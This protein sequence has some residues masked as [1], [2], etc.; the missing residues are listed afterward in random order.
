MR[1]APGTL[2]EALARLE[3]QGL[4]EALEA[5]GAAAALPA[6]RGGRRGA[7][8]APG[9]AA[10]GDRYRP[11][12]SRGQLGDRV[13]G[14]RPRGSGPPGCCAG[15][16][17]PGGSGTARS[18][19]NCSIAEMEER[20]RSAGRTLD[21]ARAGL[22]P[23][24]RPR[25]SPVPRCLARPSPTRCG[26]VSAR[27]RRRSRV[28]LALGAAMW[29]QLAI[30]WRWPLAPLTP[31]RIVQPAHDLRVRGVARLP[32]A[33]RA[34]RR[35]RL[36]TRSRGGCQRAG[37]PSPRWC[38]RRRLACS[39]SAAIISCTSGR[40]P[41]GTAARA[42]C[43]PS[44]RP[45]SWRSCGRSPTGSRPSGGT[46]RP[47]PR[48]PQ[49]LAWMAASPVALAAAVAAAV[50]LVRRAELPHRLLAYEVRLAAAACAVRAC[51][52]SAAEAGSRSATRPA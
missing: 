21:V 6:D 45:G 32:R 10:P 4:I 2:Y 22:R 25:V 38:S 40:A 36:A 11:A 31:G 37:W 8:G 35:S 46:G 52:S 50:T 3:S 28:C 42:P 14:A 29:S 47:C 18:S 34:R 23:A 7:P 19:P 49:D 24:S 16:R 51:S 48:W 44:S 43:S 33:G 13:S 26:P 12:P 9:R 41:A 1:L 15:T 30:A 39:R 17:G 5:D 27:L 20:P